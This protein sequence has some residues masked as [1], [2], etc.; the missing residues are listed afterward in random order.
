[1]P[2]KW[3]EKQREREL[4]NTRLVADIANIGTVFEEQQ[5]VPAAPAPAAK[6][7]PKPG[8]TY[9]W[10]KGDQMAL[11]AGRLGFSRQE[12]LEHNGIINADMIKPGD[13]LHLPIA[14]PVK[15]DRPISIEVLGEP[16][17]MHVAK[18]GGCKKWSFGNMESW[19]DAHSTGFFPQYTNLEIVAIAKVMVLEKDGSETEA[20]YYLDSIALGDYL[21][22]GRLAWAIGFMWPDLAEGHID[23]V[24]MLEA[25]A[26]DADRKLKDRILAQ[27][28]AIHVTTAQNYLSGFD[29]EFV[30][31][32]VD[33]AIRDKSM[34]KFVETYQ[35]LKPI[36]PCIATI[37]E[38]SGE[39]DAQGRRFVWVHDFATKRPDRKLIHDTHITIVGTFT[40]DGVLYGRPIMAAQNYN[41][42]GIDMTLLDSQAE[43]YNDKVDAQ[44]RKHTDSL[45]WSERHIWVPLAELKNRRRFQRY[46]QKHK[47]KKG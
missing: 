33:D 22:S 19:E 27:K 46:Q 45:T 7:P 6:S 37:P 15:V 1:M 9:I 20:G 41:W 5:P 28:K 29:K 30:E 4:D 36:A 17:P 14:R 10:V 31:K 12:L 38:G 47:N 11:V 35:A 23:K 2:N 34:M 26:R 18:D 3:L 21:Q 42:Y 44:T 39:V 8:S 25:A 13:V 24:A 43:L 40:Y 16:L 32:R